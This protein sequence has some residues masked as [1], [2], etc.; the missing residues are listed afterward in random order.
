MVV[1]YYE[2]RDNDTKSVLF[3]VYEN[4]LDGTL[5]YTQS[6]TDSDVEFTYNASGD[7]NEN[8]TMVVEVVYTTSQGTSSYVKMVHEVTEIIN[9]IFSYKSVAWWN[10]FFTILLSCIAIFATLASGDYMSLA[11]CGLAVLFSLFGW[12]AVSWGVLALC[13]LLSIA[14]ILKEGD[15]RMTL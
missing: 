14:K 12:F 1:A 4:N 5:L 8:K 10:W 11:I 9:E 7:G 13:L 2:D 3:N 6:S 15:R